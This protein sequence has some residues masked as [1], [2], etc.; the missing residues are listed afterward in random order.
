MNMDKNQSQICYY[1]LNRLGIPGL[2]AYH[3]DSAD[4]CYISYTNPQCAQ[5]PDLDNGERPPPKKLFTNVNIDEEKRVFKGDV[6]WA[7]TRLGMQLSGNCR[8]SC[9]MRILF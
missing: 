7:P 6:V 2:A 4:D 9:K 1:P 3:F 5:W 8:N